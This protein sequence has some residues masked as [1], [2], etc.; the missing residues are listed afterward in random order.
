MAKD[1]Q[2]ERGASANANLHD[3]VEG[4]RVNWVA[5]N[6]FAEPFPRSGRKAGGQVCQ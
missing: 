5:K 4:S 2:R 6:A 1:A 3:K